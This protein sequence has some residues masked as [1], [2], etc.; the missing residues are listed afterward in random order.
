MD[1]CNMTFGKLAFQLAA[2]QLSNNSVPYIAWK[3]I[4]I[5]RIKYT[6]PT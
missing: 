1:Q 4:F 2:A 5:I 3:A 6:N